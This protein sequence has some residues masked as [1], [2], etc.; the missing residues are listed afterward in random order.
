MRDF[1][2][3]PRFPVRAASGAGQGQ[4]SVQLQSQLHD[5]VQLQSQLHDSVQLQ[6]QLH[7]SVQ[8]QSQLHDN[9]QLQS[10][11]AFAG[12]AP[13]LPRTACCSF[14]ETLRMTAFLASLE[15]FAFLA[16]MRFPPF[17]G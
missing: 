10:M 11:L 9:V 6:S 12:D 5:K 16:F 7:D 17:V 8:L 1:A 3:V 14:V 13:S 15:V 2:V 4:E